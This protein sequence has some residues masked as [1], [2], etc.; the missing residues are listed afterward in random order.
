MRKNLR[1]YNKS[2]P[3]SEKIKGNLKDLISNPDLHKI[4]L[5]K[6]GH[7]YQKK[8]SKPTSSKNSSK[9]SSARS[10]FNNIDGEVLESSLCKSKPDKKKAVIRVRRSSTSSSLTPCSINCRYSWSNIEANNDGS[11]MLPSPLLI[12]S[13]QTS[14]RSSN[15]S[16]AARLSQTLTLSEINPKTP[17]VSFTGRNINRNSSFLSSECLDFSRRESRNNTNDSQDP[18]PILKKSSSK[19]QDDRFQLIDIEKLPSLFTDNRFPQYSPKTDFKY[20][21]SPK[22]FSNA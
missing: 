1:K 22:A 13:Y 9:K 12:E 6:P 7:Y 2:K 17:R 21:K 16:F 8:G 19:T 20:N 3:D 4:L 11:V 18:I 14:T 10:S 5:K 15:V